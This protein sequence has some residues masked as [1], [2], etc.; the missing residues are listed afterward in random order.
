MAAAPAL[1]PKAVPK[2]PSHPCR[3]NGSNSVNGEQ[4]GWY[5]VPR[6]QEAS[7]IGPPP[8]GREVLPEHTLLWGL[9]RS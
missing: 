7:R 9:I 1:V 8:E 2:G 4:D 5:E 3:S 6:V